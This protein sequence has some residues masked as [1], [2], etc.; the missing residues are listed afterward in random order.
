MTS[1][2]TFKPVSLHLGSDEKLYLELENGAVRPLTT[3]EI[4]PSVSDKISLAEL[5]TEV[6][7]AI[8]LEPI[9]V[10]TNVAKLALTSLTA[11][12]VVVVS[13]EALRVEQ[14]MGGDES[15]EGNWIVLKNT[16][17]LTISATGSLLAQSPTVNGVLCDLDTAE[18]ELVG[19][20]DPVRIPFLA[21]GLDGFTVG[22]VDIQAEGVHT[23]I[24]VAGFTLA[25]E[26]DE[27]ITHTSIPFSLPPRASVVLGVSITA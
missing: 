20:V 12:Q 1:R 8:A 11:G 25:S 26:N 27:G 14:F 5:A 21:G 3:K 17:N 7:D 22:L 23:T 9:A 19:W 18:A 15:L 4:D 10:A 16:V 6:L 13:D 24:P 2:R